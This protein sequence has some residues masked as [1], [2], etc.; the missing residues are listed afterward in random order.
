[1]ARTQTPMER[2][3]SKL[4]SA[5]RLLAETVTETQE[6]LKEQ[7]ELEEI[8]EGSDPNRAENDRYFE[9]KLRLLRERIGG[10]LREVYYLFEL[11][12]REERTDSEPEDGDYKPDVADAFVD[13]G[14]L[15]IRIPM[16]AKRVYAPVHSESS[17]YKKEGTAFFRRELRAALCRIAG[18]IPCMEKRT[19]RYLFVYG[20]GRVGLDS[21]NHDTKGITDTISSFF[22]GT[23]DN[24]YCSFIYETVHTEVVPEGTYITVTGGEADAAGGEDVPEKWRE[25]WAK[26]A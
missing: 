18:D 12:F 6:L 13:G 21:D 8:M 16:L 4:K 20:D 1:M 9:G 26:S 15:F 3:I 24:R 17:F 25:R 10:E 2:N 23:D 22:R 5:S 11:A 14:V 7:K 19:I